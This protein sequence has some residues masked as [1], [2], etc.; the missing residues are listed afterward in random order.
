MRLFIAILLSE[1]VRDGLV[2]AMRDLRLC[3]PNGCYTAPENLHLTLSFLGETAP[4]RLDSV[5]EAMEAVSVPPFRLRMEGIG[6]FHREDGNIYWAGIEHSDTLLRLQKELDTA[7]ALRGFP[8]ERRAFRPHL[9]LIRRAV[10]Y[11]GAQEALS[12]P[13]LE[14]NVEKISL[15]RSLRGD[16]GRIFYTE[17]AAKE[18]E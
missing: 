10:P 12:M 17:L 18:L 4:E 1:A 13:L 8:V 15:M 11:S 2:V 7:L 5:R 3:F 9:T 6:S 16:A 14:M